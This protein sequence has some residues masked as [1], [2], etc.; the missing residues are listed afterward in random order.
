MNDWPLGVSTGHRVYADLLQFKQK[1]G[2]PVYILASHS[3]FVMSDIFDSDYWR[4]HGGVLPGWI[5]GTAGAQ[6]YPLPALANRAKVAKQKVYGYLIGTAH[7][8]GTV[9]FAFHE[10]QRS[11]IPPAIVQRYTQSLVDYC[12]NQNSEVTS[13]QPSV[14]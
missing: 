8:D 6:R 5:V 3:H 2:K 10:I 1:T 12:F 13:A 7:S 11:D 14:K 4:G 9:D